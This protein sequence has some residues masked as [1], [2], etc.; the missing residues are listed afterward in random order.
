MNTEFVRM[1]KEAVVAMFKI[2]FR[3]LPGGTE[4]RRFKDTYSFVDWYVHIREMH[5]HVVPNFYK[6]SVPRKLIFLQN[7]IH[8][9]NFIANYR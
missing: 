6:I 5:R 9:T 7:Y 4:Q 2:P 8:L 1:W 3:Q